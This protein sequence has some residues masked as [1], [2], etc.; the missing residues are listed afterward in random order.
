[1]NIHRII[2]L[3]L[4]LTVLDGC[5]SPGAEK[6]NS[7]GIV[8]QDRL[9]GVLLKQCSRVRPKFRSIDEYWEPSE[10]DIGKMEESLR[11]LLETNRSKLANSPSSYYRQYIGYL[12][13][14]RKKIYVNGFSRSHI[15]NQVSALKSLGRK[16]AYEI[17]R[18]RYNK[19]GLDIGPIGN[20]PIDKSLLRIPV[21][22][23]DGGANYFG[24]IF[25]LQSAKWESFEVSESY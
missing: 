16:K 8:I 1:M 23:C 7:T 2:F 13:Y 21:N 11:N 9:A 10:K 24:A 15:T 3:A 17:L 14:G 25:D 18:K 19:L 22:V 6:L 5:A 12:S 20:E 4:I